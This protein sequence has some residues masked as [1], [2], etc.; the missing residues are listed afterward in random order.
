MAFRHSGFAW[1]SLELGNAVPDVTIVVDTARERRLQLESGAVATLLAEGLCARSSLQQRRGRAGRVRAGLC[2]T[3]LTQREH[4]GLAQMP[5]PEIEATSLESLCLQVRVAGFSP[6]EFLADMPTPPS[7]SRV[8]AAESMLL[9]IGAVRPGKSGEPTHMEP[10]ALGQHLAALPC[11]VHIGK[12]LVIGAFL[13]V[14]SMA[15]DVAAMLSVRSP[16][17]STVKDPQAEAWRDSLRKS[18]QPG[19]G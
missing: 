8:T 12:L 19:G 17:K 13:G 7:L 10:T 3:L 18:L 9:R 1:C 14:S 15:A 16:L 11:D 2:I 4:D 5:A 6:Q